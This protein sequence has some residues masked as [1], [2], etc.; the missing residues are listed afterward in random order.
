MLTRLY[1]SY[2]DQVSFGKVDLVV[3][4]ANLLIPLVSLG[5]S[6]A[7]I[8]FGLE[9]DISKAGVFTGGLV[10]IFSGFGIMLLFYP[11]FAQIS[12]LNGLVPLLYLYVLASVLRTLACQFVRAKMYLRLYAVDGI[13]STVYTVG[14]NVLFLV[15]LEMGSTG[16]LLSI[17][18]ADLLSTIFLMI[19][20]KLYHYI[21]FSQFDKNLYKT[22]LRFSLPLVPAFMFWWVTSASDRFFISYIVGVAE[23]GLYASASRIPGLVTVFSTVFTEAWQLS[24]VTDGQDEDREKFFSQIF[25]VLSG[26][27]FFFGAG[28][29]YTTPLIMHFLVSP[30]FFIAWKFVPFLILATIYSSFIAFQNSVYVVEKRPKLSLYTI[31]VGAIA[32]IILNAILIPV[33]GPQ[34]A[35]FA[36][37]IS[38]LLVFIIRAIN[39]RKLIVINFSILKVSINTLLLLA[40][41]FLM[42][43]DVPMFYLWCG[44][45]LAA[46]FW[47]N[48]S[49]LYKGVRQILHKRT[50]K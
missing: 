18:C 14:F 9:K 15:V 6:N 7:V 5:I 29:I 4:I 25:A 20:A 3:Q 2:L 1:T 33:F 48:V 35:G 13:L 17:I 41:S 16:Y 8:R 27:A 23:S 31:M 32:N 38:Y 28:L 22:M 11:L 26:V 44:L 46:I 40:M 12:I 47:I 36:T 24:A 42:I 34:G 37:F 49:S 45:L 50:A 19:V 39:T 10:A 21:R 43:F 30:N